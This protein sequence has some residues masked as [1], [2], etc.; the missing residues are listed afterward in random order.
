VL[1]AD[2]LHNVVFSWHVYNPG[3]DE[4][5]RIDSS[6]PAARDAGIAL[7]IGEFGPVSPGA[8]QLSVPYAHVLDAAEA[9][10]VGYLPW[11]W[12]NFNGDC[13]TGAGSA[14]DMVA[15]GIHAAQL[16]AGY[17]SEVVLTHPASIQNTSVLTSWQLSG[18]CP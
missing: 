12:D 4:V 13:N 7:V 18:T 2:P 6:L 1:A 10:G 17:A 9:N 8:C 15:D 5:A 11:S 16:N 14:F 3:S